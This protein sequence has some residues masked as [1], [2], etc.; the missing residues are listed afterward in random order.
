MVGATV[1][2]AA[3]R[4]AKA[5]LRS[6]AVPCQ[7]KMRTPQC[8]STLG[9]RSRLTDQLAIDVGEA[10]LFLKG[11][12]VDECAGQLYDLR[13]RTMSSFQLL[14]PSAML[15]KLMPAR[16]SVGTDISNHTVPA[17][18]HQRKLFIFDCAA[19]SFG[20]IDLSPITLPNSRIVIE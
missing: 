7:L 1:R 12:R 20:L 2:L 14:L 4:N 9:S 15:T 11:D 16:Y 6:I 18:G 8:D 19:K 17:V 3:L 13:A 10:V 5:V